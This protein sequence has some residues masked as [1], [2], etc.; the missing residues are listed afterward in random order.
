MRE[1]RI[2]R[3]REEMHKMLENN[4]FSKLGQSKKQSNFSPPKKTSNSP[5]AQG[6]KSELFL[7]S[8]SFGRPLLFHKQSRN[9][10]VYNSLT[11]NLLSLKQG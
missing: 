2:R 3:E 5:E 9:E 10:A 6:N 8:T 11:S 4:V 7:P 1:E